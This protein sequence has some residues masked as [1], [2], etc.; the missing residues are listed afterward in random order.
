MSPLRG[1]QRF[2]VKGKISP[3]YI[4]P[5]EIT[6]RIGAVA[7]RLASPESLAH[8]HDVFHMSTLRKYLSDPS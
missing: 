4:G 6:E 2:G 8:V 1:V 7:Y 3:R 5:A